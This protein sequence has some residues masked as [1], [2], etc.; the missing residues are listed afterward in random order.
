M[1]TGVLGLVIAGT[2]AFFIQSLSTSHMSAGK[3]L[4]SRDIRKFTNEM[5]NEARN[6]S[7]YE[8]FKSFT[9]RTRISD[10]FSGDYLVLYYYEDI[11]DA[12]SIER[13]IGYYRSPDNNGEGPVRKHDSD[14][15]GLDSQNPS[16]LPSHDEINSYPAVVELARGLADGNLFYNFY[17][18]SMM[19]KGELIH[20]GRINK[21]AT[22]TYNFTV[23]P[24]Q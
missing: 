8:L 18:R 7:R 20:D 11:E 13:I 16:A 15:T 9:D 10:G 1:A 14:I 6:A 2:M 22:N 12:D 24:R 5:T 19:V 4:V 23:S 21:R 17:G 3:L